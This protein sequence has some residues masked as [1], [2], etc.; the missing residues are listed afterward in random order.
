MKGR[1][2]LSAAVAAF[3]GSLLLAGCASPVPP[4]TRA[5]GP[6]QQGL[7]ESLYVQANRDREA[8]VASL[9]RGGFE[10]APDLRGATFM[11]TVRIGKQRNSQDC[12]SLH[13]VVYELRYEAMPVAEIK[14]RGWTGTCYPNILDQSTAELLRLFGATVPKADPGARPL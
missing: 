10:V 13:N 3:L 8:V 9:E 14:G 12:G 1:V 11:L 6:I 5:H 4:V 2:T 7:P